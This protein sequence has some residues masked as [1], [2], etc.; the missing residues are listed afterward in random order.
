ML[1][2]TF[3][4]EKFDPHWTEIEYKRGGGRDFLGVETL[5]EGILADLLPGINNQT[6]RARYYSFWAWVLHDFIYDQDAT[7]TQAGF[8]QWLRR[9][10]SA[11]ILAYLSHGC[12]GGAAGTDQGNQR[13]EGGAA[14]SYP[15]GWKSLLSVDGGGYQLYYR[16]ALLEMNIIT[17]SE[18]SPHDDLIKTVGLGLADAYAESVAETQYVRHYL[19]ATRLRKADV[20]DFAQRGCLCQVGRYEGERWRLI[21]AFFRFD[22]PHV[23]AVRRLASLC[24]FLDIIAQSD[25]QPLGQDAFRALLYFWS[26]DDQHIYR[27][28]GNLIVPAQRWRVFQLRQY[29]VFAVESLWSIFLDRVEIEALNDQEYLAWLL[30]ELD[31]SALADEFNLSLPVANPRELELQAFYETVREALPP[32][33]LKPGP[34]ALQTNLNEMSLTRQIRRE[35]SGLNVQVRA[36]Q[37]LL[38]L[39]LIYWRCQPWRGSS[40]WR[41]ASDHYAAGRMPIES[42]LR[43][44]ERA[45]EENWT[46]ARWLGWFHHRYLWLQHRRVALEKLIS[47]GQETAKF[48][49]VDDVPPDAGGDGSQVRTP[50]FRGIGADAPKMNA[51]RFPSALGIMTDLRLI[52]SLQGGAYRLCPDG[53][54]LLDRFRTYTVPE[55]TE[56]END[57][58]ADRSQAATG[59]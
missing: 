20:E 51:P 54:A 53:A 25:G 17:R 24:L 16:G 57:E 2:D 19:D 21:D 37:A 5:S 18:D 52:E 23:H 10:E 38:M 11:L 3:L 13:W 36:G 14:A 1:A 6:R 49:L 45:F 58:T 32:E 4:R 55:K 47:R 46:L 22:T 59:G 33:A 7:H 27:P 44:V 30:G 31:L 29:F 15:L 34:A 56:P 8:Y 40:G 26:F 41:Y 12:G 48:E 43:H 9:R 35:R 39:A 28:Q 50:R 42:Y